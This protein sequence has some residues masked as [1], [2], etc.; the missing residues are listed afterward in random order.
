M[1]C[2]CMTGLGEACTHVAVFSFSLK[3]ILKFA[4]VTSIRLA[5]VETQ[6]A[7]ILLCPY[8]IY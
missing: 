6:K 8:T 2:S 5:T 4:D 3:Y 1:H 7:T